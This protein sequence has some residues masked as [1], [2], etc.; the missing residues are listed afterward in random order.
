MK[1]SRAVRKIACTFC[2]AHATE[3]ARPRTRGRVARRALTFSTAVTLE[4]ARPRH[5]RNAVEPK[6]EQ[7]ER[8]R[9]KKRG[10]ERRKEVCGTTRDSKMAV[11]FRLT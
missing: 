10:K 1:E 4:R 7:R 6:A 5:R 11:E 2:R 8:Q 3:A 9:E